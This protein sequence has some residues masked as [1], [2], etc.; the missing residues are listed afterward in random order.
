MGAHLKGGK[1]MPKEDPD[2]SK[3]AGDGAGSVKDKKAPPPKK[4]GKPDPVAEE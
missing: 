4:G 2:D 1:M 3:E